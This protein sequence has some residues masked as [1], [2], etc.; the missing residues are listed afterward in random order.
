MISQTV[1][2]GPLNK[3]DN[4]INRYGTQL[5]KKDFAASH[6]RIIEMRTVGKSVKSVALETIYTFPCSGLLDNLY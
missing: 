3:S 2:S 4:N 6:E 1:G 5:D